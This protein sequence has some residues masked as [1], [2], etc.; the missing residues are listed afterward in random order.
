MLEGVREKKE[1][2]MVKIDVKKIKNLGK[3]YSILQQYYHLQ[4]VGDSIVI[5]D[6][7][8]DPFEPLWLRDLCLKKDVERALELSQ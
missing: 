3:F 6:Y 7:K 1:E 2:N 8:E 4:N 5:R